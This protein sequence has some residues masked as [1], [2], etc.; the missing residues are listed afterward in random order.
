MG[1]TFKID[2]GAYPEVHPES[3]T[4][5]QD[6]INFKNKVEAG[7]DSAITQF[8]Y[9]VDA[10]FKF[11]DECQKNSINIPIVPGI[12]PIY[13]SKQL[14]RFANNC[15]A[16]IPRWLKF[17]LED[18]S[19]DLDSLREFGVDFI[20]ELSETLIQY[21]V[22]SIHFYSLNYSKTLSKIIKNIS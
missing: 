14:I 2:V 19:D 16:E 1:D 22:P 9:N 5:K 8:F 12:M 11:V 21:G 17:K 20:S 6:F 15:G 18:Y 10:Y 13:N 3:E 7:A 4:A